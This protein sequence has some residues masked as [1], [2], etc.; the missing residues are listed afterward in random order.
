VYALTA[1]HLVKSSSGVE[2]QT[3]TQ[4]SYPEPARI[5]ESAIVTARSEEA[6][7]AVLRFLSRDLAPTAI[8]LA[9]SVGG[10]DKTNF[11]VLSVGCD[12]DA[13]P[14]CLVNHVTGKLRIKR[15]AGAGATTVWQV[16]DASA[17]G[18]SGGPLVNEAGLIVGIASGVSEGKGYFCHIDEI[19]RLL[20]E[21][22]LQWL[23]ESDA[24]E[25]N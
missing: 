25:D 8:P 14:T 6:D 5:Y 7:L 3:F 17:T 22:G 19:F 9:I 1:D 10:E 23:A 13:A 12:G 20:N 18:R 16:R 11:S 4:K 24:N 15:S 2:V 21:N